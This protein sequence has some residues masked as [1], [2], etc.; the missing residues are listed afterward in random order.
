MTR[1]FVTATKLALAVCFSALLISCQ[2]TSH[3]NFEQVRVGMD[4]PTILD[5]V[6]GPQRAGRIMGRD[7]WIY[8]FRSATEGDQIREIHFE[9][10]R[11]VYVGGRVAPNT[12]AEDQDRMNEKVVREEAARDDEDRAHWE[13][14]VGLLKLPERGKSPKKD[15]LDLRL[16][17]SM[18]GTSDYQ[19]AAREK[20][21]VAP[22][23]EPVQ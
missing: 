14:E 9:S 16:R 5:L 20:H 2:T 3:K 17:D 1:S 12:P 8:S 23:F 15:D 11:A 19:K 22:V 4:K 6:G 21:K 18:Y 7:R 10:G 13:K